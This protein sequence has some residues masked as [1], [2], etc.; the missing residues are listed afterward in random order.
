MRS[1]YEKMRDANIARN[2]AVL[3]ELGLIGG[4]EERMKP[5]PRK[6]ASA[7]EREEFS[8][9]VTRRSGSDVH[10]PVQR[11]ELPPPPPRPQADRRQAPFSASVI[12]TRYQDIP[13]E[14]REEVELE[15][16][17]SNASGYKYVNLTPT[18]RYQAQVNIRG[19]GLFP[20]GTFS[21]PRTGSLAVAL[22]KRGDCEPDRFSVSEM[23]ASWTREAGTS[24]PPPSSP[25]RPPPPSV[26]EQGEGGGQEASS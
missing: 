7:R 6:R 3:R 9:R 25:P 15:P 21:D 2:N 23:C 14:V 5:V 1:E 11:E 13:A 8:P 12:W 16:S 22:A 20:I 18:G 10:D 17:G 26:S 24:G 4:E 19:R